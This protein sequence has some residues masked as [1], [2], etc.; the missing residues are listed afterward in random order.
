MVEGMVM[1]F[2]SFV[3]GLIGGCYV[4]DKGWRAQNPFYKVASDA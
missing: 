1:V 2:I 3:L 4:Y